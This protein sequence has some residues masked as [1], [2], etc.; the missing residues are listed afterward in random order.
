MKVALD[1]PAGPVVWLDAARIAEGIVA[2][3][4]SP[5]RRM[6]A[7]I[8]RSPEAPVQRLLNILQP[9]S[10]VQP[11]LHPR[12]QGSETVLVMQGAIAFFIFDE[13]GGITES[14]RLAA[15]TPGLLVDIEPNVWHTFAATAPDTVVLEIKGGPYDREHDKVFAAWAPEET[16]PDAPAY[17]EALLAKP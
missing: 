17:L 4:Q 6:M 14:R 1:T 5:R 10:Y 12:A 16:A 3:R 2:S 9:G 13:N 7:P 8:Q 11:H 15:G